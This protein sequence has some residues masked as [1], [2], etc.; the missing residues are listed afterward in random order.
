MMGMRAS[1]PVRALWLI[2]SMAFRAEPR[3]AVAALL[4]TIAESVNP[5]IFALGMRGIVDAAAH[6]DTLGAVLSLVLLG[7]YLLVTNLAVLLGFA[8]RNGVRERT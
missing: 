5:A 2:S 6:R 4:V 1:E 3:G 7:S 8:L